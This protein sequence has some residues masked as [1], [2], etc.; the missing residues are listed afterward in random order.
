M[1]KP[2]PLTAAFL[3]VLFDLLSFSLMIPDIQPRL[4]AQGLPGAVIG[5]T[6][7]AYSL[8]QLAFG[9]PIGR[10]SDQ[11]GRRRTLLLTTGFSVFAAAL[12]G[13]SDNL[14]W[15]VASR[16]LLGIAGAN[17]GVAY[18]YIS[19]VTEPAKR[20]AAMGKL[21]M[22]FG[23]GFMFG[24]ILG[25]VLVRAGGG[26]PILL[27]VCSTLLAL[28]NFL[29]VAFYL[30][31]VPPIPESPETAGLGR[32]AKL[33]AAL[34]T[35]GLGTLLVLFFMA[36]FAFANLESTFFRLLMRNLGLGHTE[37]A[38]PGAAVLV[39]V[40]G[41]AAAVQGGLVG[42]LVAR[43]GELTLMRAGYL[44]QAPCLA[45]IP[46]VPFWVP[47]L[48]GALVL[49]IG[50]GIASPSL[51]SLI[52]RTAPKGMAGGI[53]GVTQSLGAFARVVGPVVGNTLFDVRMWLPYACAGVLM[54]APLTL[55]FR[56]REN[57]GGMIRE[58]GS[59]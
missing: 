40:G 12:Y 32:I 25:A 22:A 13:L 7:A 33:R 24:P 20:A 27:A 58:G 53:F 1:R 51:T 49:G 30:P 52:S 17:L 47:F 43:F 45:L 15:M 18:A 44:V 11:V 46:V 54:L 23:I 42:R 39:F 41:V 50:S 5:L 59:A 21:G 29:F 19:D 55:A 34:A 48:V 35:P 3:T 10:W 36:N 8:A 14:A 38:I 37:V 16:V 28:V 57:D 2:R 56:F 6:I 26:S 4:A 31:D 9:A